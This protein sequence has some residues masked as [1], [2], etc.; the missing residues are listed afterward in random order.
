MMNHAMFRTTTVPRRFLLHH[1][2]PLRSKRL[3]ASA[4]MR[5]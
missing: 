5:A 1:S 2:I 3:F 4:R